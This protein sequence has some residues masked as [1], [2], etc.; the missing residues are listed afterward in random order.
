MTGDEE[1]PDVEEE[2]GGLGLE[3]YEWTAEIDGTGEWVVY[4]DLV[5]TGNVVK[6][7]LGIE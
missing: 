1:G 2:W 4:E 3:G 5:Y 7:S 6:R